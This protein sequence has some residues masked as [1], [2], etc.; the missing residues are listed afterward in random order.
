M[1]HRSL[2]NTVVRLSA[3]ADPVLRSRL[4]ELGK[5]RPVTADK[6]RRELGWRPRPIAETILATADSLDGGSTPRTA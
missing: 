4:Y 2:P 6:A 3:L 1:P 5:H